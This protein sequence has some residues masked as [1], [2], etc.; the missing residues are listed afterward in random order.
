M[1]YYKDVKSADRLVTETFFDIA[2]LETHKIES[3]LTPIPSVIGA[4]GDSGSTES[5]KARRVTEANG[6][7]TLNVSRTTAS[8]NGSEFNAS[9]VGISVDRELISVRKRVWNSGSTQSPKIAQVKALLWTTG[10]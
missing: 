4:S 8:R 5:F 1:L 2:K 9:K 6:V 3:L 7:Y 10:N